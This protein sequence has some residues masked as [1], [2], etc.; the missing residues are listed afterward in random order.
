MSDPDAPVTCSLCG[1]RAD[2]PGDALTW[3]RA[4]ENGRELA[5]CDACSRDN[6]RSIEGKLDSEFW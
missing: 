5:F 2:G 6:I 4:V 1:R 3:T